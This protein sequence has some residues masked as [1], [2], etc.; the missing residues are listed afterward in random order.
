MNT[1]QALI[2]ILAACALPTALQA[3]WTLSRSVIAGGGVSA[4]GG[5]YALDATAGQPEASPPATGV[6][7]S[8][9]GGF[10]RSAT[11]VPP[12]VQPRIEAESLIGDQIRLSWPVTAAGFVLEQSASFAPY[13]AGISWNQVPPPYETNGPRVSLAVP[14]APGDRFYR[15]RKP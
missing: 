13:E 8:L 2:P 9:A 7:Y 11:V 14:L 4:S 5:S 10:W 15:L 12:V 1:H 6:G 3:Q